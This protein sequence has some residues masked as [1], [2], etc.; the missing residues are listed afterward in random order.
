MANGGYP[1]PNS[2]WGEGNENPTTQFERVGSNTQSG[3]WSGD[4][5]QMYPQQPGQYYQQQAPAQPV[6]KQGSMLPVLVMVTLLVLVFLGGIGL[7]AYTTMGSV[8]PS[9]Q[10]SASAPPTTESSIAQTSSKP[11]SSSA[12]STTTTRAKKGAPPGE[13]PAK[14]ELPAGVQPV[15]DSARNGAEAGFLVNL[16]K[17]GPTSDEFAN[18]VHQAYLAKFAQPPTSVHEI[19]VASP[20]TLQT[21]NMKCEDQG[22]YVHCSGGQG[23]HVYIA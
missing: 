8:T 5:T 21:Y 23:A 11:T 20:V 4:A 12:T 18:A 16:Y 17:S 14:A 13:R 19:R 6:Q 22:T 10:P 1:T 7:F 3:Y 9:T 15:N 2:N